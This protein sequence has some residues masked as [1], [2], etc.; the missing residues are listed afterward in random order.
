MHYII[1]FDVLAFRKSHRARGILPGIITSFYLKTTY[2]ACVVQIF[3]ERLRGTNTKILPI[4][5]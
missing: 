3:K 1:C 4:C 2:N 5:F